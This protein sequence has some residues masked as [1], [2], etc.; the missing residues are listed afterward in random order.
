MAETYNSIQQ[1]QPLRVPARWD[2]QEKA[3]I[4][5]LDEILDDLYRRF[6]RLGMQDM[7]KK[8][9]LTIDGKYNVVSGIEITEEGID[10][11]GAKYVKIRSGGTFDV[12]SDNFKIN[13]EEGYLTAGS[14]KLY[15]YGIDF[16]NHEFIIGP[17]SIEPGA[18]VAKYA[19]IG[20]VE[21]DV[22]MRGLSIQT[23][24]DRY[25]VYMGSEFVS[26]PHN[27]RFIFSPFDDNDEHIYSIGTSGDG[28]WDYG[29]IDTLYQASSR[30]VKHDIKPIAPVG[31]KLDK[32][33]PVSFVYNKDKTET[34]HQGLIYEDT[35]G[36]LPEI[37]HEEDG[38]K[39]IN[40]IELV[41]ILLKEI[42]D[43]RKRVAMLEG[44]RDV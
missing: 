35:V 23:D 13:S 39:S 10:V 7:S 15:S 26:F 44:K 37:C 28:K 38:Q 33:W 29:Y 12:D 5:Q 25:C 24:S 18:Q 4:I 22:D 34:V 6:G 43:L 16:H 27:T 20:P 41:P 11:S 40:Y 2:K 17:G 1:H 31:E 3:L 8:F 32:L 9:R 36:I 21:S 30:L 42:Q 14:W 19:K